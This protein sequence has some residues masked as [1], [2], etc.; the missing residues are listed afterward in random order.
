MNSATLQ[1]LHALEV[2]TRVLSLLVPSAC[3]AEVVS[4]CALAAL[5][6]S[7]EW[8]VGVMGWRSKPVPVI[9]LEKLLGRNESVPGSLPDARAGSRRRSSKIVVFYPLPGRKPWEF[10][11][12]VS[13]AEP[14]SLVVDSAVLASAIDTPNSGFIAMTAQLGNSVVAIPDL[15]ALAAVLYP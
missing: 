9:S 3:V 7:P 14:Q 15:N 5:P 11:G 2:P 13:C 6:L 1:P 12:I 4:H 8:V 10:F